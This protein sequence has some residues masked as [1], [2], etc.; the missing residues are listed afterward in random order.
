MSKL[1]QLLYNWVSR[2]TNPRPLGI[3]RIG[4][5]IAFLID[6]L[7]KIDRREATF[8]PDLFHYPW[9][10]WLP[11]LPPEYSYLPFVLWFI[12][13]LGFIVG[14]RTRF[15][16]AIAIVGNGLYF[17]AD[18]QNYSNHGYLLLLLIFLLILADSGAALS[19]DGRKQKPRL[20]SAWVV[21]LLKIQLSIVY[22][23]TFIVKLRPDWLSGALMYLNLNGMLAP[24]L[25]HIPGIYRGLAWL[26]LIAEGFLFWALW[27]KRWREL[28]FLVGFMLHL[29]ILFIV[30]SSLG[31]ISFGLLSLSLYPLFLDIPTDK[32][33]VN[34]RRD[35][36]KHSYPFWLLRHLDWLQVIQG[37]SVSQSLAVSWLEVIEPNGIQ[38]VSWSAL[39]RWLSLLP[40]TSFISIIFRLHFS[41]FFFKKSPTQK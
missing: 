35:L 31:L 32:V 21:D 40:L 8:N 39:H 10:D 3:A 36:F 20:V 28:A 26:A 2:K 33:T 13:G 19:L 37:R 6:W 41:K 16:G 14:Y 17:F 25:S 24:Y 5:G 18:R 29:G 9:A 11:I 27:S 38:R 22:F 34:L 23:F 15:S 7:N 12:G 30:K 1:N 4:I